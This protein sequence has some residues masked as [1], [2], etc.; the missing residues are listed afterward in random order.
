MVARHP[1]GLFFGQKI[2]FFFHSVF[3]YYTQEIP[4]SKQVNKRKQERGKDK[5][6]VLVDKVR[7]VT[8]VGEKNKGGKRK[9]RGQGNELLELRSLDK[10][11]Y[12]QI[13]CKT[14]LDLSHIGRVPVFVLA[15]GASPK[16]YLFP[17]LQEWQ[18]QLATTPSQ[19]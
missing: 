16:S 5:R 19:S 11:V 3:F 10:T 9:G 8:F 14:Y 18:I 1:L 6:K 7:A 15:L 12:N 4:K 13:G 17:S 2:F